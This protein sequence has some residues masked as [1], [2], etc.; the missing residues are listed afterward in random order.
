MKL[1]YLL[2]ALFLSVTV[3]AWAAWTLMR[4]DEL[5]FPSL[6]NPSIAVFNGNAAD[7]S[8]VVTGKIDNQR[9]GID[10][11][12]V[13]GTLPPEHALTETVWYRT[14]F[15]DWPT[16]ER[17]SLSAMASQHYRFSVERGGN[18]LHR[19]VRFC[20]DG[21]GLNADTEFCPLRIDPSQGVLLCDQLG[22]CVQA[23]GKI[24]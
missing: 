7:G 17:F 2:L 23:R 14:R 5:Q 8:L 10:F 4:V 9:T 1:R 24:G 18:G 3:N 15:Q 12:P 20:F 21:M 11:W 16:F 6:G 13:N 22:A 19:Q